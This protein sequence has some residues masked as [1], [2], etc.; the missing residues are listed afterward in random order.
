M[1]DDRSDMQPKYRVIR[2][3]VHDYVELPED[4]DELIDHPL[5]QRLRRVTQTAHASSVFPSLTGTRFEHSL[6]TMHLAQS[7]WRGVWSRTK[8]ASQAK[9]RKAVR[10]DLLQNADSLDPAT[11]TWVK[12]DTAD[13][14]EGFETRV[15]VALAAVGLLHDIGHPPYSHTLEPLFD[16]N[17]LTIVDGEVTTANAAVIERLSSTVGRPFHE[18]AGLELVRQIAAE[19]R[20]KDNRIPWAIVERVLQPKE[21]LAWDDALSQIVSSEVDTDRVDY[22][23]RDSIRAGTQLGSFDVHRLL[24]SLEL[25]DVVEREPDGTSISGWR[26]GPG[27]RARTAIE[28]LLTNRLRYHHWVLFHPHV[29]GANKFQDLCIQEALDI[30]RGTTNGQLPARGIEH[31]RSA[32]D[33]AVAMSFREVLPDLNYVTPYGHA[34]SSLT[35][36]RLDNRGDENVQDRD[37][38]LLQADVDDHVI[39][40]WQKAAASVARASRQS[41]QISNAMRQ[42]LD[43]FLALHNALIY[44]TPNWITVWKTEDQFSASAQRMQAQLLSRL[45]GLRAEVARSV[46]RALESD[47]G[48]FADASRNDGYTDVASP[49][50]V[51]HRRLAQLIEKISSNPTTGVNELAD[52]LLSSASARQKIANERRAAD[53]LEIRR[54][55][56]VEGFMVLGYDRVTPARNDEKAVRVWM[57]DAFVPLHTKSPMIKALPEISETFPR[58]YVFF[59]ASTG[60]NLRSGKTSKYS[61]ALRKEFETAF[62]RMVEAL[63]LSKLSLGDIH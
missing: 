36:N 17:L 42:R 52:Y 3:P 39:T 48:D 40:H 7:T 8:R 14:D 62:P 6:G 2:D 33:D 12:S 41:E 27:Y 19:L 21:Y 18:R 37:G 9:F 35:F 22:L 56:D 63:I 31:R 50:R 43:R 49:V 38:R 23:V 10:D 61:A 25:H 1:R 58:F 30:A 44:R 32:A 15:G 13:Y 11:K 55:D 20:E 51:A 34:S 54:I 45:H 26:V 46:G 59:I 47:S 53:A 4:L 60:G 24:E 16:R 29:A 57:G 28:S 5:V